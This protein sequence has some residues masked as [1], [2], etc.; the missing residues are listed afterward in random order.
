MCPSS[1]N[2]VMLSKY[3]KNSGKSKRRRFVWILVE[4]KK[5]VL[6]NWSQ[7]AQAAA[8]I[9]LAQKS[10]FCPLQWDMECPSLANSLYI[11]WECRAMKKKKKKKTRRP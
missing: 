4:L 7:F 10:L 6:R 8:F 1:K 9:T 5:K 2:S 3:L 11:S